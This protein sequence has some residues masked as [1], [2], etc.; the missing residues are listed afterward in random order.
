MEISVRI[1][2]LDEEGRGVGTAD[3]LEIHVAGAL[4]GEVAIA[5]IEHRSPH[6]PQAWATLVRLASAPSSDRVAPACP[7]FGRCGG[8]T[9][10]HL[11]YP[12]QLVEKRG[13]VAR[14]LGRDVDAVVPAP[15]TLHY[16]NKGKYVVGRSWILGSYAPGT[17]EIVDMAGCRVLEEPIDAVA[18]AL[19]DEL[20]RAGLPVYDEKTRLGELRYA[21]LRANHEGRVLVVVVVASDGRRAA[22]VDIAREL[23][24]RVPAVAGVV[25]NVNATT[26]GAIFGPIDLPLDGESTLADEIGGLRLILSARAFFQVNRA[27]A[28]RM[29]REVER[30]VEPGPGLRVVDLFTGAGGIALTL[31]ARGADVLGVEAHPEAVQDARRSAAALGLPARFLAADAAA[32]L[33]EPADLVVVNPPRKGLG[34][35][36]RAALLEARPP[37]VVYVSC[38]PR[39]L[40]DDLAALASGYDVASV[41]PFDLMPGT[42]QVE[43]VALLRSR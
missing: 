15:A 22:L 14:A 3:R 23:R 19:R 17:H 29:Y 39:S 30:L 42:P 12:A 24:R 13:R 16:R 40:G 28:A 20:A 34:A 21:V 27:A 41:R 11:A 33:A 37:R 5:R 26:G 9:L 10:Q 18:G 6:S 7:A 32:G 8:C 38:G 31:A 36:T 1:D 35:D 4:P 25:A 2:A 43:T